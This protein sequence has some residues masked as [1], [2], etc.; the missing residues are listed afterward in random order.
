M[1]RFGDLIPPGNYRF[2]GRAI[3]PGFVMGEPA[4]RCD[5]HT[6]DGHAARQRRA[7]RR[8]ARRHEQRKAAEGNR[9]EAQRPE[10]LAPRVHG[11]EAVPDQCVEC[12]ERCPRPRADAC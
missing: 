9:V 7:E 6:D 11:H 10:K 2:Q 3:P 5:R 8:T 4:F 1:D 12:V